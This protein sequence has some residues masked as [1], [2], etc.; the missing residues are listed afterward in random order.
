MDEITPR[1]PA[2]SKASLANLNPAYGVNSHMQA[3][4]NQMKVLA[5]LAR[6][7][8]LPVKQIAAFYWPNDATTRSADRTL[9]AL[10]DR[11]EVTFKD[12]A[13]RTRLY[14]LTAAGVE[15]VHHE[16]GEFAKIDA[17]FARRN[18][19]QFDHRVICNAF[20]NWWQTS[21]GQANASYFTEHEVVQGQAPLH[22]YEGPDFK[23]IPDTIVE[24]TTEKGQR[25]LGWV[26]VERG[27][28]KPKDQA[29]MVRALCHILSR[30]G[31]PHE[32]KGLN[33]GIAV[34][35]CPTEAL[36]TKLCDSLFS[37]LKDNK[38]RHNVKYLLANTYI[39]DPFSREMTSLIEYTNTAKWVFQRDLCGVR[40]ITH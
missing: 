38:W 26:E 27:I 33:F 32:A 10:R 1:N 37:Y 31:K 29:L 7:G 9:A 20:C 17:E 35:V 22:M 40:V 6:F 14:T 18:E 30:D 3:F 4:N 39:F 34:V 23:K 36:K 8:W 21:S 28:K 24:M 15:R 11:R 25:V 5:G 13:D 16:L 12:R 19:G 2:K